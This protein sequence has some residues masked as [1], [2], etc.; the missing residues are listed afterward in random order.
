MRESVWVGDI[1]SYAACIWLE[2]EFESVAEEFKGFDDDE[3]LLLDVDVVADKEDAEYGK[4][5]EE[6]MGDFT[7]IWLLV[8]VVDVYVD[9][10]DGK[11]KDKDLSLA[12]DWLVFCGDDCCLSVSSNSSNRFHSSSRSFSL[13]FSL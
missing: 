3:L 8:V 13:I 12:I 7:E 1:Y 2:F 4:E 10:V 11:G 9:N 5:V 6:N